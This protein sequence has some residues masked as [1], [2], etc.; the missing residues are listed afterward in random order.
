MADIKYLITA[1]S[2]GAVRSIEAVDDAVEGIKTQ[3]DVTT[4]TI[5]GLWAQVSAGILAVGGLSAAFRGAKGLIQSFV[6]V[7]VQTEQ[8]RMQLEILLGS[9]EAANNA[10]D[11]FNEVAATLPF[12]LE[13]VISSGTRLAAIDVPFKD[14]LP[15]IADVAA[16]MGIDLPTATD[17]FARA[18]KGGLGAADLFREK[19]ISA[20]IT[21]FAEVELGI[22]DLSKVTLPELENVLY[23]FTGKFEGGSEKMAE[24]W[25]GL[26]SMLSDAWYQFRKDVMDAGVMESLKEGLEGVLE[27]V[28]KL[29]EEG[30]LQEWAQQLGE[31]I[32][33]VT[34][35][36]VNM[37]Y[38]LDDI[39]ESLEYIKNIDPAGWLGDVAD[40][41]LG[42]D[43]AMDQLESEGRRKAMS[44]I[45][46]L[47]A[48]KP[49]LEEVRKEIEKGPDAWKA[50]VDE[51][52][53]KDAIQARLLELDREHEDMLKGIKDELKN[54]KKEQKGFNDALD[55]VDRILTPLL[56]KFKS[57]GLIYQELGETAIPKARDLSGVIDQA[58]GSFDDATD[59]AEGWKD[60]TVAYIQDVTDHWEQ[61]GLDISRNFGDAVEDLMSKGSTFEEDIQNLCD[62]IYD[63]FKSM[64]GNMVT[65]WLANNVFNMMAD[66]AQRVAGSVSGAAGAAAGA[67]GGGGG[68]LGGAA[69]AGGV[70]TGLGAFAG[71][72]L[73]NLLSG[74]PSGRDVSLTKEYGFI[75]A[76]E[77]I[78]IRAN[79][80]EIKWDIR[81]NLI[82]QLDDIR[83]TLWHQSDMMS[84]KS[85][86][87]FTGGLPTEAIS[88]QGSVLTFKPKFVANIAP[89]PISLD[90]D[91]I[92]FA[93]AMA[94]YTLKLTKR[95]V[96]K[97]HV[98][99]LVEG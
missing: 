90:V 97:I 95:G 10:F 77:S 1:D 40:K 45:S 11:F 27:W 9:Q 32:T 72:F 39:I 74:G 42:I 57:F 36:F 64:I 76:M 81:S 94:R 34:D 53:R 18:L 20:M 30:R 61:L 15:R 89:Q 19:G 31:N 91:G 71:T 52:K 8:Y 67:G 54:A 49:P 33:K 99:A 6:D 2:K 28:N 50:Y 17:Q 70:W 13:E 60:D 87:V 29:K 35:L 86:S 23:Q 66:S 14:W 48:L 59:S 7:G 4:P 78:N 47:E 41:I 69:A 43:D 82:L 21:K 80:D 88:P 92:T 58:A 63:S 37:T 98:N 38:A 96:M 25:K 85:A 55:E 46:S 26:T 44:F 75:T 93:K 84:G 62:S 24:S 16:G 83:D 22:Q 65:E 79:L 56:P 5:K 12:T 73:G 51:M 3:A 68:L